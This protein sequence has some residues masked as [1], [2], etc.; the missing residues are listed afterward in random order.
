MAG[1]LAA[2]VAKSCEVGL[3]SCGTAKFPVGDNAVYKTYVVFCPN[4]LSL[5][6]IIRAGDKSLDPQ[7]AKSLGLFFLAGFIVYEFVTGTIRGRIGEVIV[8]RN[9]HP[10]IYWCFMAV[11]IVLFPILVAL[12]IYGLFSS[13]R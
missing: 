4:S 7:L 1:I 3:S 12:G 6:E 5:S 9:Q 13:V 10:W 8:R 2:N 11:E